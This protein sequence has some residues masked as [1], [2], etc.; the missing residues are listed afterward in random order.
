[1]STFGKRLAT[2][3][4]MIVLGLAF[5]GPASTMGKGNKRTGNTVRFQQ[6][7]NLKRSNASPSGAPFGFHQ[8]VHLTDSGRGDLRSAASVTRNPKRGG[9]NMVIW[10]YPRGEDN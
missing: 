1:M 2:M 10:Q 3:I 4:S 9:D 8:G 6:G 5:V 7:T